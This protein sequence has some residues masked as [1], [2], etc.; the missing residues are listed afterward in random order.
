M[1][2]ELVMCLERSPSSLHQVRIDAGEYGPPCCRRWPELFNST[3]PLCAGTAN[4]TGCLLPAASHVMT[5]PQAPN[6]CAAGIRSGDVCCGG[7]CRACGT[8]GEARSNAR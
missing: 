4:Q 7:S 1:K 8:N 2:D 5:R 6:L 3:P